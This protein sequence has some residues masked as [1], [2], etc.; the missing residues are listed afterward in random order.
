MPLTRISVKFADEQKTFGYPQFAP[1]GKMLAVSAFPAKRAFSREE[2]LR[3]FR[4]TERQLR[5]WEKQ[6]LILARDDFALNELVAV[7]TL[8]K[9]RENHVSPRQVRKAVLALRDKMR[10]VADPLTQFR[11]FSERGRIR[12]DIDGSIMEP[13]SGQLLLNFGPAELKK[14]LAF[15][16]SARAG[17]ETQQRNRDRIQAELLFEK[18]LEMEHTGA[19]AADIVAVYEHALT[20]DLGCTGA[21]VNLGTIYFN[22][23]KLDKAEAY[24]QRALDADPEYALARFNLGNLYDEQGHRD[25]AVEQYRLALKSNPKYSDAHY[26]LALLYQNMGAAME[27]VRHWNEYLKLDPSSSW[28]SIAR[29][30]LAKLKDAAIV[31]GRG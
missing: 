9:L 6:G 24:Y 25:L 7:K 3:V 2:V 15:P 20:L 17:S 28:A 14:L 11:I 16:D 19:P 4:I 10:D 18:G 8:V 23:R 26:N 21:L 30:E 22:W 13:V 1:P 31:G 12:V 27:A 5:S 29:R